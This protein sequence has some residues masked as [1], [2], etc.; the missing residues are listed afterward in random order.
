MGRNLIRNGGFERGDTSFWTAAGV[1]AFEVVGSPTY[2][3]D[4]AG[5]ATRGALGWATVFPNDYIPISL[6]EELFYQA[7]VRVSHS[8]NCM[9]T[10]RYYDEG[11][12]DVG[13]SLIATEYVLDNVWKEFLT[14]IPGK[15]NAMYVRPELQYS[16]ATTGR[17]ILIDNVQ[18]YK[19]NPQNVIAH[20]QMLYAITNLTTGGTLYGDWFVSAAFTQ[21]EFDLN[22][23]TF[24]GGSPL[25]KVTIESELRYG[26]ARN[27]IATFNDVTSDSDDQKLVITAALGMK[28]RVKAVAS[29]AVT[30][31][32]Y[33]VDAM[34]KR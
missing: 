5:K 31:I 32:S 23:T 12:V 20:N 8:G 16:D 1:S 19:L 30:S 21:A 18:A 28:L 22:I 3:G 4:Y 24:T 10:A 29:G 34:F 17:Y 11:L 27:T 26:G 13:S 25:L 7:Y 2:K 14:A 6:G 9:L 15:D 33:S